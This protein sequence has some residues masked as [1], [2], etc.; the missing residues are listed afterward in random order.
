MRKRRLPPRSC[1]VSKM[2]ASRIAECIECGCD[3]LHACESGCCWLRLDRAAG[4]GV[5][6]ECE[7]RVS[8]WDAGDRTLRVDLRDE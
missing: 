8:A 4:L 2:S 1:G 7:H 6:S 5:C 3:D